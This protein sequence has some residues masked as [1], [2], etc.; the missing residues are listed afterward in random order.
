MKKIL[1]LL[2]VFASVAAIASPVSPSKAKEVADSFFGTR[3]LKMKAYNPTK[4]SAQEPSLYVFNREGG[5]F[6]IVAGDDAVSPI[7]AYSDRGSFDP[8]NASASASWWLGIIDEQIAVIRAVGSRTDERAAKKWKSVSTRTKGTPV[9]EI[10]TAAWDQGTPYNNLCSSKVH[11]GVATGCV[12]T[13]AAIVCRYWQWPQ[14]GE[15]S[16]PAYTT[17]SKNYSVPA[18]T[19]GHKYDYSQMPLTNG[20]TASWTSAQKTQVAQLMYDLGQM[21]YMDY[22][23]D[24]GALTSAL[25]NGLVRHMKYNKQAYENFRSAH[26]D[27]EWISIL[28]NELDQKR[29]IIYG[30]SD[31]EGG[32]QFV[33]DGYDSENFFRVNWGWGGDENG[34]FQLSSLGK[35]YKFN[36]EQSA[37]IG[38]VPDKNG[39]SASRDV[40]VLL[41]YEKGNYY[42]LTTNATKFVTG[43]AF[44]VKLGD[45][46]NNGAQ[47][48]NGTVCVAVY[49]K[50]GKWKEDVSTPVSI[51]AWENTDDYYAKN[52]K[53]NYKYWS[54]VTCT[55]NGA[56]KGGDRLR[57]H[58][59][60]EYSDDYA[61]PYTESTKFEIVLA[62]ADTYS[63]AEIA[64]AT[65]LA[66]DKTS[67]KL[68]LKSDYSVTYKVNNSSGRSVL[69]GTLAESVAKA[70][71]FSA[72]EAGT[73]SIVLNGGSDDLTI[74]FTL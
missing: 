70:L 40:V 14:A 8:A 23:E 5:G 34:Y 66:Y 29:P 13:A 43:Q 54:S 50:N 59:K 30:G 74:K 17:D 46:S 11:S 51:S 44:T 21:S 12:A 65:S 69:S 25:V 2:S 71:D 1:L 64:E 42:G 47:N 72:L 48:F 35:S 61:L 16:C 73:Y 3:S 41:P 62:E 39:S 36:Y 32:H 31:N 26:S 63:A 68:T 52:G 7:L 55:I 33:L 27:D 24:S 6:V 60:G 20:S 28:K 56:I 10:A 38:L 22:D 49:D 37:I 45:I 53:F 15:G 67:G 58:Y 9:V 19:L 4:A 18:N 57:V